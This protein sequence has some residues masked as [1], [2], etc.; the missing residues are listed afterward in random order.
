[1]GV[2]I[3]GNLLSEGRKREEKGCWIGEKVLCLT[4]HSS[5]PSACAIKGIVFAL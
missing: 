1:V 5:L 4:V 3:V 2:F